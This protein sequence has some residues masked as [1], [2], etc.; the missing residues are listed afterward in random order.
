MMPNVPYTNEQQN[1]IRQHCSE[2]TADELVILF[3]ENFHDKRSKKGLQYFMQ[4]NGLKCI[5]RQ[6]QTDKFTAEQEEFIKQHSTRMSRK[7]L[8]EKFNQHFGTSV[9]YNTMKSW[10][11]RKHIIS[12]HGNGRFT[13]ETSPRWQKGLSAEEFKS[14]YTK[15]SFDRMTASMKKSNIRH[16][17]GDEIMRHGLPYIIVNENFGRGIDARIE[18]KDAYIWKQHHGDIPKDSMLIHLDGDPLN[19]DIENLRCIPKKYRA[20]LRHN[21]WWNAP[22]EV[23][24]AA[25]LW[26]ELYYSLK[27]GKS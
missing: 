20:F 4:K 19:C 16:H 12:P 8:T 17:V 21:D 26:C 1:F 24:E 25:L 14:H 2:M 10:C 15:E 9:P 27:E 23:K 7:E 5:C 13:A 22:K 6:K 3:N 18:K 11:T